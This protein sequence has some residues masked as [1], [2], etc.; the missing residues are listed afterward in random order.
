MAEKNRY[1]QIPSAVWWGLRS[2]LQRTPK[3]TIDERLLGV[4]L[5]VQEA[6]ARAY[7]T[8]LKNVGIIG[9]EGKATEV[10]DK[11]RLDETY[12]DAVQEIVSA[13][14][15]E[16]LLHVAPP[17]AAERQKVVSWFQREGLGLG[18]AGN[19][20]ATY[21]LISSPS[22]N[23]APKTSAKSG[24]TGSQANERP[25]KEKAVG[26]ADRVRASAPKAADSKK[27]RPRISNGSNEISH[28]Q[29]MP[30]NI[31]V[32]IHISADA[33]SEQIES[34]FKAMR[35]YLYDASDN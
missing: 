31:N 30:L 23:E 5:S 17:G 33:G 20:A 7:I 13:N 22:P 29:Q 15:P 21:L 24:Q 19:K 18:A 35:R 8:E 11:W 2:I 34:I 27:D 16:G 6:A 26:V 9:E 3:A 25:I 28:S 12:S 10:A 32:Q 1:P 4:Q 14:Y